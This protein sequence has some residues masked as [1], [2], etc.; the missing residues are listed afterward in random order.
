MRYEFTLDHIARIVAGPGFSD[1]ENGLPV[2]LVAQ[3]IDTFAGQALW[4]DGARALRGH[5]GQVGS[6]IA[7]PDP[8]LFSA[9]STVDVV[10]AGRFVRGGDALNPSGRWRPAP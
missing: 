3:A 6:V 10:G 5:A 7:L 4:T 8:G 2:R 9:G 1:D